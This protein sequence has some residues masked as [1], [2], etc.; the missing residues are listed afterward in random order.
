[1]ITD[2]ESAAHSRDRLQHAGLLVPQALSVP[3][4]VSLASAARETLLSTELPQWLRR[5]LLWH[6]SSQS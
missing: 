3:A 1:M 6:C 4:V 2:L 5:S